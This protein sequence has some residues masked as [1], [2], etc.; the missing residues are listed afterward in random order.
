MAEVLFYHLTDSTLDATLPDLVEKALGRGW[1]VAIRGPNEEGLA[2]LSR[3]L[4]GWK[5]VGFMAHDLAPSAPGT[6]VILHPDAAV[7]G[8]DVLMVVDGMPLPLD[9]AATP[10][11]TCLIFNDADAAHVDQARADWKAVGAAGLKAT[12]WAQADGR[13]VKRAE[14]TPGA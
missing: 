3:R 7:E 11:R 5:D 4:W 13:W 8:R 10:A 2:A 1:T 6:P 14:N 12:Y 9:A